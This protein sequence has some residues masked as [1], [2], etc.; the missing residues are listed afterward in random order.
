MCLVCYLSTD[1][2]IKNIPFD[3]NN[4]KFNITRTDER[5]SC[6]TKKFVYYCG[7][8][9]K[10]GCGFGYMGITEELLKQ[11]EQELLKGNLSSETE[12]QWW[13]HSHP[14]LE[15]LDEFQNVA[16]EILAAHKDNNDLCRL[17]EKTVSVGFPCELTICW[18]GNENNPI[19]G[20]YDIDIF[21]EKILI[22][23]E[24]AYST[25]TDKI[26]FYTIHSSQN[27]NQQT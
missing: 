19:Q 16:K 27:N 20:E 8:H 4:P 18:N 14:P 24:T 17:I 22:D 3:E 21:R 9:T 12:M 1:R 5:F 7:S 13:N 6:F 26:L 23:F 10:C 2:E 25:G 11:T 15:T